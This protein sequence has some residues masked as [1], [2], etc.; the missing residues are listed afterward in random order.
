MKSAAVEGDAAAIVLSLLVTD[1]APAS[2]RLISIL[3][4]IR[5]LSD[6]L[7]GDVGNVLTYHDLNLYLKVEPL[8]VDDGR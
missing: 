2:H 7:A 3:G 8:Q 5:S 1:S 4:S 6:S